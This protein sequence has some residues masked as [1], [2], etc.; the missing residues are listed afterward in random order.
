MDELIYKRRMAWILIAASIMLV[1]VGAVQLFAGTG[2]AASNELVIYSGRNETLVEP[3]V[4]LFYEQ[5]GIK[6]VVRYGNSS[7]LVALI[8]EEGNRSRAD[9]FWSVD[10]GS[11]GALE[12]EGRLRPLDASIL[13]K[14][15]PGMRSPSGRW[16]ATSGRARVIAYNTGVH[17]EEDLPDGIWG[18][19]DPKWMGRIGWAP[20]N[21]SFQDFITALR[22]L[23]G[24]AKALEWLRGI[25]A[26]RPRVY[27]SNSAIVDAIARGEVDVGFINHYYV[28]RFRAERGADF[29][30]AYY[31][32]KGDAGAIVNTAGI[33][34]LNTSGNVEAAQQFIEFLLTRESQRYFVD[35]IYEYPVIVDDEGLHNLALVPLDEIHTPGIDL[36]DLKDLAGTL[37]LLERSGVL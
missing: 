28:H 35:E 3:L 14:V 26:N 11:L 22:V 19:T 2:L 32:P 17:Q 37:D 29:P 25:Q 6:P 10:A 8:L 13:D 7:E 27:A 36:N 33:G 30:V 1:V 16:V 12:V 5:T 4:D 23:E 15:H 20:T 31:H 21:A 18:F 34:I 9:L 24:D